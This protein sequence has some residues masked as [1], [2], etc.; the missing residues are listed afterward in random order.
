MESSISKITPEILVYETELKWVSI[1][2]CTPLPV[3][4]DS[5]TSHLPHF[6]IG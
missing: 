5:L 1:Y 4:A 2:M 6:P 3:R